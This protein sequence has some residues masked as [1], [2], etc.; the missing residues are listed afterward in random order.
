M[1]T[2]RLTE[3]LDS[4]GSEARGAEAA[5]RVMR[6]SLDRGEAAGTRPAPSRRTTRLP[7]RR[8]SGA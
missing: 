3:Q 6:S 4:E 7:G 8:L 5:I 2:A 1:M